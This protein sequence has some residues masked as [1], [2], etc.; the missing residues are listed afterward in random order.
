MELAGARP[1]RKPLLVSRGACRLRHFH[2]PALTPAERI[3]ALQLALLAWQPYS[4]TAHAVWAVEGGFQAAAADAAQLEAAGWSEPAA[5]WPETLL[6]EPLGDAC[7]VV[8]GI[9]GCEAQVWQG[10]VLRHSRWWAQAPTAED[11]AT[12]ARGLGAT[13][14]PEQPPAALDLPWLASPWSAP[15]PAAGWQRGRSRLEGLV[16]GATALGLLGLT[17]AQ[18]HQSWNAWQQREASTAALAQWQADTAPTAR[19]RD[20]ALREAARLQTELQAVEGPRPLEVMVHL[21]ELLPPGLVLKAFDLRGLQV[22]LEFEAPPALQR[23]DLIAALQRSLWWT[24]ISEA[25]SAAGPATIALELRLR[26]SEAPVPAVRSAAPR[27]AGAAS[28]SP[29]Q[30]LPQAATGLPPGLPTGLPPGVVLPPPNPAAAPRPA[31]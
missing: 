5:W 28:A 9:D 29:L 8:Q 24:D 18:A 26:S 19:L 14:V 1:G 12:F 13:P 16:M 20:R 4:R 27:V 25:R 15:R 3:D 6:R 21:D 2:W 31:R 30:V 7:R 17:A 11:W 22:K 10:G 23:S